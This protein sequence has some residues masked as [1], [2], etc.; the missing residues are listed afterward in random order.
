MNYQKE[1][2][3][4]N[5]VVEESIKNEGFKTFGALKF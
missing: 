3:Q 4:N 2:K 1:I 5:N